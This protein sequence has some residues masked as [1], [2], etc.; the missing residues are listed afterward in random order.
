MWVVI[1]AGM[2]VIVIVISPGF[3]GVHG[4]YEGDGESG[5]VGEWW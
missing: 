4:R 3:A 5:R 1:I 2:I